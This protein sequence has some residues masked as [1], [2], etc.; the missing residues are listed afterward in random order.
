MQS[1]L[2][3][4]LATAL[5]AAISAVLQNEDV[6]GSASDQALA[7]GTETII[8]QGLVATSETANIKAAVSGLATI[9]LA[10]AATSVT[11][12][13]RRGASLSGTVLATSVTAAAAATFTQVSL[14]VT[15]TEALANVSG[16]QYCLTAQVAADVG[17]VKNCMIDTKVLS[18]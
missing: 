7:S 15:G 6:Q 9:V 5:T 3:A 10:A 12:R 2:F 18:G 4:L 17:T 1:H 16:A 11:L 8:A 13:I 14:S